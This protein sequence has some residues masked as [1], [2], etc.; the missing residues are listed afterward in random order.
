MISRE[1]ATAMDFAL[2]LIETLIGQEDK[3]GVE[4]AL[5]SEE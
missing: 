4:A 3:R 5:L 1:P 2:G